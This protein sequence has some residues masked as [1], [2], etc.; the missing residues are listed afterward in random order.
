[1]N[2]TKKSDLALMLLA[3]A[4]IPLTLYSC[5]VGLEKQAQAN[6]QKCLSWQADGYD[7]RCGSRP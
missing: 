2:P 4:L 7:V 3:V 1:M 6:Y 5:M